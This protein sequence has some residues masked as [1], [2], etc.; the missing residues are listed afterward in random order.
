MPLHVPD[1]PA[2][3]ACAHASTETQAVRLGRATFRSSASQHLTSL[4]F[5]L[6]TFQRSL[7]YWVCLTLAS[8]GLVAFLSLPMLMLLA[9][10]APAQSDLSKQVLATVFESRMHKLLGVPQDVQ[11]VPWFPAYHW[12]GL[13]PCQLLHL[14]SWHVMQGR[15]DRIL[16]RPQD[17]LLT[18]TV[19]PSLALPCLALS[20]AF[21]DRG[22]A[23]KGTAGRPGNLESLTTS[24]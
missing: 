5:S 16:G 17:C 12:P 7:S 21:T 3:A 22:I 8:L 24:W 11:H 23:H 9:S 1:L 14:S 10:S 15:N 6:V 4:P 2:S 13:K 20:S 19:C 18:A